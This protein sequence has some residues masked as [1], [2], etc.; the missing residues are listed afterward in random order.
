MKKYVS[1]LL[2]ITVLLSA[3]Q[4]GDN[5]R[6]RVLL[7]SETGPL[8][9]CNLQ[10]ISTTA[11]IDYK[12]KTYNATFKIPQQKL[13]LVTF[14]GSEEI[15]ATAENL[16]GGE[17]KELKITLGECTVKRSGKLAK[18]NLKESTCVFTINKP[19]TNTIT[20]IDLKFTTDKITEN[21]GNYFLEAPCFDLE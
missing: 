12:G 9:E 10:I 20:D 7:H 2:L 14:N 15:L 3:C 6:I 4:K 21:T 1:L 17:I 11:T 5:Q 16:S 18:L 19:L 13:N 8:E